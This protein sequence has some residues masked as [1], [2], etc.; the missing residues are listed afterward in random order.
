MP[1]GF[2]PSSTSERMCCPGRVDGALQRFF[3]L[4][5]LLWAE[6]DLKFWCQRHILCPSSLSQ[7]IDPHLHPCFSSLEPASTPHR[8]GSVIQLS[9]L[10]PFSSQIPEGLLAGRSQEKVYWY[11]PLSITSLFP[12]SLLHLLALSVD[13]PTPLPHPRPPLR[14]V[15]S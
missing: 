11:L 14:S 2:I 7:A 3:S 13:A 12:Q 6:A 10:P 1:D 9:S 4:S 8:L 5:P 15:S